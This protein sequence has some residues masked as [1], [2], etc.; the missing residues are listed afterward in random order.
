MDSESGPYQ[1]GSIFT[2][3]PSGN[4][5]VFVRDKNG[6]GITEKSLEIDLTVDGFPKFFTPNG[7]GIN[8][9]WQFKQP[10]GENKVLTTIQIFDRYGMLLAQIDQNAEGWDGTYLGRPLP[11]GGVWFKAIGENNKVYQGHFTLKR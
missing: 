8:D 10:E 11:A 1:D 7:D 3:V 6:C 2:N 9:F 5:T 4:H